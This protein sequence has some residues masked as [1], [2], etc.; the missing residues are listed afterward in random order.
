MA[1]GDQLRVSTWLFEVFDTVGAA[2][3]AGTVVMSIVGE[4]S[5]A[6]VLPDAL[7]AVTVNL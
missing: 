4:N 5:D 1:G 6:T 7:V 2:G 3:V